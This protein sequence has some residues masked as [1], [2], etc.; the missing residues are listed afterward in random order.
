[1]NSATSETRQQPYADRLRDLWEDTGDGNLYRLSE[2]R[3][4]EGMAAPQSD[5]ERNDA[6]S[7]C[8]MET[9]KNTGDTKVFALLFEL[10]RDSFLSAIQAKVRRGSGHV[11]AQ[12]GRRGISAGTGRC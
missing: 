6:I 9:F 7:S 10:N 1:M 4:P 11:D 5:Q 12:D 2:G 8:L 3:D